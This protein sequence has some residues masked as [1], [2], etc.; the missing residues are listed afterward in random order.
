[1]VRRIVFAITLLML[2]HFAQAQHVGRQTFRAE[3]LR[4]LAGSLRINPDSIPEGY[5]SRVVDGKT[6]SLVKEQGQ[7]THIGYRL[8]ER[9]S[10][11]SSHTNLIDFI[12]RYFL[13]L[14]YP[15]V[16]TQAQMHRDFRT[17]FDKGSL[18]DVRNIRPD[19]AFSLDI[20]AGKRGVATWSRGEQPFLVFSFPMEYSVLSGEDKL[21]AEANF[22]DDL[23]RFKVQP[24]EVRVPDTSELTSTRQY[25]LKILKGNPYIDKRLNSDTYYIVSNSRPTLIL[26]ITH[27]AESSANMMLN[28][29]TEG[30]YTLN[31]RQILYGYKQAMFQV[32]LLRWIAFCQSQGCQLYFGIEKVLSTEVR[33]SV[34]AVNEMA[35]YNHVMFVKIPLK[36][37]DD[38][39]GTIEAQVH[40]YV[41]MHNVANLF[42]KYRKKR[43]KEPKIYER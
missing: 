23:K 21:E 5:S 28:A 31:I 42:E 11:H 13:Q 34:I 22:A 37:I 7:L 18:E 32:P 43:N 29:A 17:Q 38:Q 27:P 30:D 35:G 2:G 10:V 4:Q 41:P 20:Q 1:M 3:V 15:G 8:F 16:R 6:I 39:K 9:D 26:D 25:N 24:I 33:A 19:D 14:M 12:E 36:V 40:S